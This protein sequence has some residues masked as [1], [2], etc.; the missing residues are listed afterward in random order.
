MSGKIN[1]RESLEKMARGGMALLLTACGLATQASPSPNTEKIL[2]ETVTP[3]AVKTG[4][5]PTGTW[6]GQT[7]VTP[8][9]TDTATE[10]PTSNV[11]AAKETANQVEVSKRMSDFLSSQGD[12]TEAKVRAKHVCGGQY[13]L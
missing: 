10:A 5:P 12:Y 11:D 2:T 9:P 3:M 7:T 6:E 4:L 1:G 13:C 8:A